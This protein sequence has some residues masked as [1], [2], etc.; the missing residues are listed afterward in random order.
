MLSS[1]DRQLISLLKQNARLPITKIAQTLGVSRATAQKRLDQLVANGVIQG[2][3]I[4]I[5]PKAE[6]QLIRAVMLIELQGKMSRTVVRSLSQIPQI[7]S[8]DSTNGTW[9]LVAQIETQSL[10]ELDSTLRDVR[11]VQGVTSS[12]T[13]IL[14]DR[15]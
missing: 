3:T 2:F 6:I 4:Q 12:E 1:T 15:A 11:S 5:D 10:A 13:C 7:V 8:L 14:L 9:D